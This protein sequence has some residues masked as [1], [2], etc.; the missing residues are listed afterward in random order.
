MEEDVITLQPLF[1]FKLQRID[2][3]GTVVGAIEPTGLRPSFLDKFE[4]HGITL[5]PQMFGDT[6]VA[7]FGEVSAGSQ[8]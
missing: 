1:E 5:S 7:M 8:R 4:R 6:S 3:D 2:S